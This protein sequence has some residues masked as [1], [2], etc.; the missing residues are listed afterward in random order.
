VRQSRLRIGARPAQKENEGSREIGEGSKEPLIASLDIALISILS[1]RLKLLVDEELNAEC[2]QQ[3]ATVG[4]F[5]PRPRG[6]AD[7]RI[8]HGGGIAGSS[9]P[10]WARRGI[11]PLLR[12]R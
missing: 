8:R 10:A 3:S 11:L 4:S 12:G 9:A 1:R 6:R 2:R 7:Q 5:H